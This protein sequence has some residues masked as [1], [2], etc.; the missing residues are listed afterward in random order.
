[1]A[2]QRRLF[3][4]TFARKPRHSNQATLERNA[5]NINDFANSIRAM[6]RHEI[7][8]IGLAWMSGVI[9]DEASLAA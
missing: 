3:A 9:D 2:R 7:E 1:M 4:T 6:R 5:G 8:R